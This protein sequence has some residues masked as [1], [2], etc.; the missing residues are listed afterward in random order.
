MRIVGYPDSSYTR[1]LEN[2]KLITRYYFFLNGEIV[3]W[4]SRQ[5]Q[6]VS[7]LTSK[8]EYIVVSYGIRDGV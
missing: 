7:I 5:Q 6:T 2:K 3:T 8:A 1:D 4:F